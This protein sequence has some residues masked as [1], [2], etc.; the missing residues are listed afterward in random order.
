MCWI[1]FLIDY[2]QTDEVTDETAATDVTAMPPML[3]LSRFVHL[4]ATSA[5]A[6]AGGTSNL[7][8]KVSAQSPSMASQ[9]SSFHSVGGFNK[10]NITG[11]IHHAKKKTETAESTTAA[12]R[13]RMT[14]SPSATK[15]RLEVAPQQRAKTSPALNKLMVGASGLSGK[16][17]PTAAVASDDEDTA[18]GSG[19]EEDDYK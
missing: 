14:S 15:L 8:S 6:A 2:H 13:I 19:S 11:I 5:S 16:A 9:L 4:G 10:R 1:C 12:N 3:N 18:A 7:T 17:M